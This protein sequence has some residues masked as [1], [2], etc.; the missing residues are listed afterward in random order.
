MHEAGNGLGGVGHP[1]RDLQRKQ[2]RRLH[3]QR[4]P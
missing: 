1:L 4:P 2:Q 3:R